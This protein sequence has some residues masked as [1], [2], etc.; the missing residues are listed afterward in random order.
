MLGHFWDART[1]DGGGGEGGGGLG[2]GGSGGGCK[3][4]GGRARRS[5]HVEILVPEKSLLLA[6]IADWRASNQCIFREPA[7]QRITSHTRTKG[8]AW[9][10]KREHEGIYVKCN[11]PGTAEEAKA[12]VGGSAEAG[13][14]GEATAAADTKSEVKRKS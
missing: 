1:G 10:M 3:G 4:V 11:A 12:M 9:A 6:C 5:T 8:A 14:V 13:L 2:G 7:L